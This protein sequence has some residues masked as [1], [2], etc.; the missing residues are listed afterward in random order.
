MVCLIPTLQRKSEIETTST[1][2]DQ[3]LTFAPPK[4]V[5]YPLPLG[6]HA[7]RLGHRIQRY[8]RTR[9]MAQA[10]LRR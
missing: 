5:E 10:S 2:Q 1:P 7:H 3:S 8:R 6:H 4:K 9:R